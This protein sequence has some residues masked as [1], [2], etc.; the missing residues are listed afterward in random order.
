MNSLSMLRNLRNSKGAGLA[1]LA[2]L[3]LILVSF[4]YSALDRPLATFL[5]DHAPVSNPASK[6]TGAPPAVDELLLNDIVQYFEDFP[7]GPPFKPVFGELGRR[8]KVIADWLLWEEKLP[9]NSTESALLHNAAEQAAL[10][11]YPFL[12]NSPR[13]RKSKTPL[14]DLRS[15]FEAGSAGIVIPT[16]DKIIRFSA[17]LIASLRS[18]LGSSLPIQVAYA[19]DADLS[20][21]GR[22][23]LASIVETGA[24]PLEFL[25][26]TAI[27]DD[28]TLRFG[29]AS[30][31]WALKAFAALGSRFEKVILLDADAVFL[32]QPEV[33]LR[34][35][36]FERA[37]ALLFH[38]RLLWQHG[39]AE[40]HDWWKSQIHRPSAALG[41]SRVWTE[42]YAEEGDSG[43]VVVDKG[44][45]EV[46]A[47][48]LHVCWQNS[49]DVREEITYKI[50]YG[51]KESW[52]FGFELT[53]APYEM[54]AHYGAIVGWED[55]GE[56]GAG[57]PKVCSF[58]IA[59]VDEADKLLWYNG[60]LL[61][62]KLS[63]DVEYEVPEKWMIDADWQKGATKQDMSCM[64]GGES[65]SLTAE[66]K[67][68]LAKSIELAKKMDKDFHRP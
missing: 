42:D 29:E 58:V 63:S 61:K 57:A 11:L 7:L 45:A 28:S 20:P 3:V 46:L 39:F 13:D 43:V 21:G 27:F 66:E 23:R 41:K 24:P 17:H 40:R 8:T 35:P 15:S 53:G 18:V 47:G 36:A 52:W 55:R 48:L 65:R 34:H 16:G 14:S 12:S 22:A 37:G 38:D 50:T 1:F 19:G 33:L 30:G 31:G 54:E 56:D 64:V 32:Q 51:D 25:D 10:S 2:V 44:R 6:A 4:L 9:E 62:N 60:G 59:H 49:F 67:E 26:V 5:P 68:V